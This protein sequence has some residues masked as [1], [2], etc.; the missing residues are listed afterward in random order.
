MDTY[1][2]LIIETA[3]QELNEIWPGFEYMRKIYSNLTIR[4]NELRSIFRKLGY[5]INLDTGKIERYDI[6]TKEQ[7]FNIIIKI[8]SFKTNIS[9]ELIRSDKRDKMEV[10]QARHFCHYFLNKIR[11]HYGVGLNFIGK[12][13]AGRNHASVLN[14]IKRVN[15]YL[16]KKNNEIE[17][18][19]LIEDIRLE[20]NDRL[21]LNIKLD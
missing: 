17:L 14:S 8:I 12:F 11:R 15:E 20:I 5:N 13:V 21:G 4:I 3:E 7:V 19:K 10:S 18:K 16:W 1:D 6:L 9:E 2:K